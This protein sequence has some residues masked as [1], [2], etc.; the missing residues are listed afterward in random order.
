MATRPCSVC[1]KQLQVK[2]RSLPEPTCW[3]C[4]REQAASRPPRPPRK[5][6]PRTPCAGCGKLMHR[7]GGSLPP[8]QATCRDCRSLRPK[9]TRIRRCG[10]CAV[11]YQ[12][13]TVKA[14]FCSL[15]CNGQ[16]Q[17]DVMRGRDLRHRTCEVCQNRYRYTYSKQRTCGRT[18]G[19][20]LRARNRPEPAPRPPAPPKPP[21]ECG[22][23]G[24]PGSTRHSSI[25]ARAME[26]RA[27]HSTAIQ[28]GTCDEC[29]GVFIRRVGRLGAYCSQGCANRVRRRDDKHKRKALVAGGDR[30]SIAKL[31]ERDGW[32]CHICRRKVSKQRGNRPNAP[33]IDHLVPTSLHGPH[34]WS[35][36]ALAHRRC[37]W[38]RSNMGSA[39]LLLIAG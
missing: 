35:N 22:W 3:S 18:C 17:A 29:G 19:E 32:R 36:V 27:R 8:G 37:N 20:I 14:R 9:P 10:W 6:K 23:C 26:R 33:S 12:S 16:A 1:A 21:R 38:E 25:C 24:V 13:R 39:Q 4:R 5:A 2:A 15:L 34:V 31:G 7:G 11:K 28:Y 30:I